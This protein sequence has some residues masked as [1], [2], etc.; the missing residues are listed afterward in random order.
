MYPLNAA[1][2]VDKPTFRPMISGYCYAPIA[3]GIR[4]LYEIWEADSLR[5]RPGSLAAQFKTWI[6]PPLAMYKRELSAQGLKTASIPQ[7]VRRCFLRNGY[8][9]AD[10][11]FYRISKVLEHAIKKALDGN[12][13]PMVSLEEFF[14]PSAPE[15]TLSAAE[16]R[17]VDL[18]YQSAGTLDSLWTLMQDCERIKTKAKTVRHVVIKK[19]IRQRCAYC[20]NP[21]EAAAYAD[22]GVIPRR[23][24]AKFSNASVGFALKAKR[25]MA[26]HGR[27][28]SDHAT[29]GRSKA[30]LDA[31][32]RKLARREQFIE[33]E[34]N[35]L[36]YYDCHP[37]EAGKDPHLD[38]LSHF[39]SDLVFHLNWD[40]RDKAIRGLARDIVDS[41]MTDRKKVIAYFVRTGNPQ[42]GIARA[43]KLS[44]AAVSKSLAAI[45]QRYLT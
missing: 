42:V 34:V 7:S 22:S 9:R 3:E 29:N 20:E 35:R 26:L 43:M 16:R 1:K 27:L 23:H 12:A 11:K 45:P 5:R 4:A 14:N 15:R 31:E 28:C 17:L 21:T 24:L 44:P 25:R 30:S 33:Q 19:E 37:Y 36:E 41:G 18:L 13:V 6:D 38:V 40:A 8:K 10:Y 39:Y 32:L 2:R